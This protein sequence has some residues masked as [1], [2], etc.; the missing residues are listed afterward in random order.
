LNDSNYKARIAVLEAGNAE[1]R[2]QVGPIPLLE[3]ENVALKHRVLDLEQLVLDLIKK[4][5]RMSFRK[6]SQNS[7]KAPSSDY[8]SKNKSLRPKSDRKPG[9]QAG[10][11]GKTLK[12]TNRPDH[13]EPLVPFFWG[14]CSS[15]LDISAAKLVERRQVVDIP[16][17]KAEVTEFRAYSILCG[18]VLPA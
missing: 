14:A 12:M 1:L 2:V 13:I 8:G 9:G 7:R 16:P 4:A 17:I 18:C 15:T 6:D 5:E 3:S 10:H 11:K